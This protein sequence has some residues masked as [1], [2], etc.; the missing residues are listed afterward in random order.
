MEE[1]GSPRASSPLHPPP[2]LP[3][4][5]AFSSLIKSFPKKKKAECSKFVKSVEEMSEVSLPLDIPIQVALSMSERVL[6]GQF[7]GLWPSPKATKTWVIKNWKPL[8]KQNV[9][10]H[11]L[12]RGYFLFEFISKEDKALIF[13][14]GPYFMGPQGLYLNKWTPDFDPEEDVPS[15]VPV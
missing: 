10:S 13:R 8:M 5:V 12:G 6:V 7:T 15:A 3:N 14:N 11:F 4:N 1:H 2:P 9:T